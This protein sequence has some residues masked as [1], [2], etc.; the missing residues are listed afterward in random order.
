MLGALPCTSAHQRVRFVD[1]AEALDDLGKLG[2]VQGLCVTRGWAVV[3]FSHLENLGSVSYRA[4]R[5][6]VM[7]RNM[8]WPDSDL[9]ND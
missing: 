9:H 6:H 4:Q 5:H 3:A 2:G 7:R 8:A 1:A